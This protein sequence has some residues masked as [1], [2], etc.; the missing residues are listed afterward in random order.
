MGT[1]NYNF[2]IFSFFNDIKIIQF[3]LRVDF[4]KLYF[5]LI[6]IFEFQNAVAC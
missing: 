5:E 6:K 2:I 3:K 4:I 1:Y